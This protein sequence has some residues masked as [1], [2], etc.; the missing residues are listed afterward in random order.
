MTDLLRRLRRRQANPTESPRA[1]PAANGTGRSG[2]PVDADLTPPAGNRSGPRRAAERVP[3]N[4]LPQPE[5]DEATRWAKL[6]AMRLGSGMSAVIIDATRPR[7]RLDHGATGALV[8]DSFSPW[9]R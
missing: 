4:P 5:D 3:Y 2:V 7:S 6:R 8:R 9:H 1:E